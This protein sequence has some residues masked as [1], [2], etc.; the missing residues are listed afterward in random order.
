MTEPPQIPVKSGIFTQCIN[1]I[2]KYTGKKIKKIEIKFETE[3]PDQK[4]QSK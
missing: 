3:N 2:E 4:D 1:L